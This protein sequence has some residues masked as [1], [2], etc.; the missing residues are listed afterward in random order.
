M[1][2][3]SEIQ[4][5]RSKKEIVESLVHVYMWQTQVEV[6]L[7]LLNGEAKKDWHWVNS[8]CGGLGKSGT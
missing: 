5:P 3:Y 6:E 2:L 4:G 1:L 8:L 7:S